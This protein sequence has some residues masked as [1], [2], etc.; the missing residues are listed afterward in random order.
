MWVQFAQ[1]AVD[2][3][4]EQ[5]VLLD[6][7]GAEALGDEAHDLVDHPRDVGAARQ[8]RKIERPLEAARLNGDRLLVGRQVDDDLG[9]LRL[10][11]AESALEKRDRHHALRVDIKG[12]DVHEGLV[13]DG[14]R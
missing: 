13:R 5:L 10:D 14:L 1:G 3:E 7:F 6:D 2:G 4:I 12:V 11:R 9:I 8:T